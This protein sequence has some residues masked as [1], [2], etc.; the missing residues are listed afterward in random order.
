MPNSRPASARNAR[1][2]RVVHYCSWAG[3]LQP[4][5]DYLASLPQL[6]LATRVA[7]PNDP[8][9]MAM[10]R[11]DCDWHAENARVF[12]AMNH[13]D[14]SF[15]EAQVVGA[16]GL[17][18]LT[19]LTPPEGEEW[20]VI[21]IG[22]QPEHLAKVAGALFG[23]LR[24]RGMRILYYAYDEA[25]RTMPCFR[26]IAP[27]LDVLIHDEFP[28]EPFGRAVLRPDCMIRHH[29][30]VAN[31]EPF[32]HPFMS[33]PEER[34]LF[35][36]SAMGFTPHR[37]RQAEFLSREFG[38]RFVAIHDHSVPVH[39]RGEFASRFKVS[40]CPEGRKFATPTMAASHTDRPFWSGCLGL[41]PVSEDSAPGGRLDSL[42]HAGVIQRYAHGDLDS[43]RSAC[44]R[45]LEMTTAD[46]R[47]IYN[48]FNGRETVGTVV[49]DAISAAA[50]MHDALSSVA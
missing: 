29:S 45:A 50:V 43:L 11:L 27:N 22:Q 24:R 33:N 40:L 44:T 4:A 5:A 8:Q 7:T 21:F 14:L 18:Q 12:A 20:W 25:S 15:L 26:A 31:V 1:R 35:L 41:V 2:V 28:L 37:R 42:H 48:Y 3:A 19:N 13:P 10:A 49:A 23:F 38:D 9:A 30:W 16:T 6:D 17:Q 47:R 34:I 36:G 39:E 32:A 46:R